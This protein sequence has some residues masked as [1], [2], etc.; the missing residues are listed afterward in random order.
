MFLL[1]L[2]YFIIFT[3]IPYRTIY[4]FCHEDQIFQIFFNDKQCYD[5]KVIYSKNAFW[6]TPSS[7]FQT[8]NPSLLMISFRCNRIMFIII[9]P[10]QNFA[11][12]PLRY[13]YFHENFDQRNWKLF[14]LTT[15][16][17]FHQKPNFLEFISYNKLFFLSLQ[18]LQISPFKNFFSCFLLLE[19]KTCT[20]QHLYYALPLVLDFASF[21][22][23]NPLTETSVTT[24]SQLNLRKYDR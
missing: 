3:V 12:I 17:S 21:T 8:V 5:V 16:F 9:F 24:F 2:L 11:E 13:K 14:I 4:K 6:K 7:F 1:Y 20:S 19:N 18:T 23:F 22:N 15:K 10:I